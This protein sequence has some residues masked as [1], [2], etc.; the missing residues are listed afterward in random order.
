M[1]QKLSQICTA[2]LCFCI[3]KVGDLQYIFAVTS[4]S[5]S[6]MSKLHM[7]IILNR[8]TVCIKNS[9][10]INNQIIK[11]TGKEHNTHEKKHL[12]IP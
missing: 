8:M 1:T 9:N 5:P 3:G 6:I 7:W 4:G 10:L 2:I 11:T 12:D